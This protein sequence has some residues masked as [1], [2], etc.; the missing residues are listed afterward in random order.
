MPRHAHNLG[1]SWTDLS[2]GDFENISCRRYLPDFMTRKL[3]V[4]YV[5]CALPN[6][7]LVF[8]AS[9]SAAGCL[10]LP[11]PALHMHVAVFIESNVAFP[12]LLGCCI[13]RQ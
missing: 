2:V 7:L 10:F 4:S 1:G 13:L 6:S 8:G 5:E 3:A 11:N 12:Q 9:Q